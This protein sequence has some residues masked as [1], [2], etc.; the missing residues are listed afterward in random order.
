MSSR[1]ILALLAAASSVLAAGCDDPPGLT[2]LT[3]RRLNLEAADPASVIVVVDYDATDGCADLGGSLRG[4][5]NGQPMTVV[6]RGGTDPSD[7]ECEGIELV[8]A[9]GADWKGGPAT[10]RVEDDSVALEAEFADVLGER[11]IQLDAPADGQLFVGDRLRLR[12]LTT[13]EEVSPLAIRFDTGLAT[14]GWSGEDVAIS[15]DGVLEATVPA[16]DRTVAGPLTG[17]LSV[18][19]LVIPPTLRCE[20]AEACTAV[21]L[22]ALAPAAPATYFNRPRQP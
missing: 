3:H 5:I 21:F 7:G 8:G 10:V 13:G 22:P 12:W 6:R 14:G 1:T 19:A 4:T 9:L 2:A 17:H 16:L 15:A 11:A 18:Q 20:G